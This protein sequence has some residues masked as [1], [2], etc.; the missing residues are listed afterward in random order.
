[1]AAVK[2]EAQYKQYFSGS[3][4]GMD[5]I[6]DDVLTPIF[7]K[8]TPTTSPT[9]VDYADDAHFGNGGANIDHIYDYG[10]F[11]TDKV[12]VS[13]F[14][15]ILADKCQISI[16]RKNIQNT[17][18]R[19]TETYSGAFIVFHYSDGSRNAEAQTWRLS[20]LKRLDV[21]RKDSPAKRY[22]Y[23]CGPSYSCR[24]IAQRFD[25]LQ[26]NSNKTLDSI[27]MA[28]DV[29]ALSKDFFYEYKVFYDDIIQWITGSRYVGEKKTER[30]AGLFKS[31]V[32]L[33][34]LFADKCKDINKKEWAA[35][36]SKQQTDAVEKFVRD[37]V[38]KLMGRMVFLQFIQ[39]KGWLGIS[40]K[41]SDWK[42]GS[43]NFLLE[44]FY[45]CSASN[46][47]FLKDEL[48]AILFDS[49]NKS[50]SK[51]SGGV[52]ITKRDG[53]K[54]PF[55]N[56]G[57][58]E[59]EPAD[60]L[61]IELP[62]DFFH[63][64]ANKD[65]AHVI[66]RK[67]YRENNDDFFSTCG[68]LDF[69]SHYNFTID[70]NASEDDE[71]EVGIDP[72][73]LSKVFENL[74]E[75]NKEKGAFYTPKEIVQ[76]MCKESLVS[77]LCTKIKGIDKEIR[78]F[79][80][81]QLIDK[82]LT[83]Q[84][85]EILNALHKVKICDPAV[86][87][88]AF[89]MGLL[90]LILKLRLVLNDDTVCTDKGYDYAELMS[91]I[92]K[93]E[94][95]INEDD[96]DEKAQLARIKCAIKKHIIQNNI[97]GVDI[98]KGAVDLAR[99][100]FW[101]NI[102]VDEDKPTPLPNL[103]FKIMQGNSL[104]ECYEGID[105]SNLGKMKI[106]KKGKVQ[107]DLFGEID[108]VEK[109]ALYVG[110]AFADF[111]LQ[112]EIKD[113]MDISDPKNK[114]KARK[115]IE[116]YIH[117][118]LITT[119]NVRK[120]EIQQQITRYKCLTD[121]TKK[122]KQD[123]SKKESEEKQIETAIENLQSVINDKFFLWHTWFADVFEN[124]G[125]DI[126]IGNPPYVK[127]YENKDAFNL[128]KKGK[129][130]KA[131]MDLWFYF[132]C[133][134]MDLLKSNGI[135]SFIAQP[136][137]RTSATATILRN[138]I[139]DEATILQLVDFGTYMVFDA[140]TQ[141]MIFVIQNRTASIYDFDFKINDGVL[142]N[143]R[144]LIHFLNEKFS[145]I[146]FDKAKFKN[147]T[148]SFVT[149]NVFNPILSKIKSLENFEL[150][151][152][153]EIIQG[154]IGG[155]DNAFKLTDAETLKF[156]K[157]ESAFIK[158]FYT[159][160]TRYYTPK[161]NEYI[162]YI[163]DK[164]IENV[165][166]DEHPLIYRKLE[167]YKDAL[168][169]RREVLNGRKS[170]FS[171]WWERDEEYF[172]PCPKI[173]YAARTLGRNFTYTEEAFYAS[174]NCFLI[175]TE[176]INLKYLVGFLNSRLL[177]LYM[178]KSLKHN[179]DMLQIDKNQFL[180]IPLF[181]PEHN[182]QKAIIDIVDEILVAKKSNPQVDTT[183]LESKID[184]LVYLLYDLTWDE[185]QIVESSSDHPIYIDKTTY[186]SWRKTYN[187]K[188]IL[189]SEKDMESAIRASFAYTNCT[190]SPRLDLTT[191]EI[192][193]LAQ[194]DHFTDYGFQGI[195]CIDDKHKQI[196]VIL[197]N[198]KIKQVESKI[199]IDEARKRI[200]KIKKLIEKLDEDKKK[201]E[202]KHEKDIEKTKKDFAKKLDALKNKKHSLEEDSVEGNNEETIDQNSLQEKICKLNREYERDLARIKAKRAALEKEKK[203]LE[204]EI[205]K[206]KGEPE[207]TE[208][209][210]IRNVSILGEYYRADSQIILY[211]ETIRKSAFPSYKLFQTYIHEMF[212][213]YYDANPAG[214]DYYIEKV[215]EPITE[216]GALTFI[217]KFTGKNKDKEFMDFAVAQ[218]EKKQFNP[219]VCHYGFGA[220]LFKKDKGLVQQYYDNR[221]KIVNPSS[222]LTA[223][224]DMFKIAYPT[225]ESDCLDKL[226]KVLGII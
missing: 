126:V 23:L 84:K 65:N 153:K 16:A 173:V 131:K 130:Y 95:G 106:L 26:K 80:E 199:T 60:T 225:S 96:C 209:I 205:A 128:I 4:K 61:H 11:Y 91:K 28:F 219:A 79:V 156:S 218:V 21:H 202:I 206:H 54:Y 89:P 33:Y 208:I 179:G 63:N 207:E 142:Q 155:P 73:M 110:D 9:S 147:S 70:E 197:K 111:D 76:Y 220:Y 108:G 41:V 64:E 83:E 215:E 49:L 203:E 217:E 193:T 145:L 102:V 85:G 152:N 161:T 214:P 222:D 55:L 122:Q 27:T 148:F 211:L 196:E 144:D 221:S 10:T 30:K 90:N 20:W 135:L 190:S 31:D 112:K 163:C 105:L 14:E 165:S 48:Y 98:E 29:E 6:I 75:D 114:Q 7:G 88:G 136:Q 133:F 107:C 189:P 97:Y 200:E 187:K 175:K 183:V 140:S 19:I 74:L 150:D 118:I 15:V 159:S 18:R 36:S 72:E 158:P 137:W 167:P 82:K 191:E 182:K 169:K 184:I 138:K 176:K 100:R 188:G 109:D 59:E 123:W 119:L 210:V 68:L 164:N 12:D 194:I 24:T 212:H 170:W 53:L 71:S 67:G 81:T 101:L 181:V 22:T 168:E 35:W 5:S 127:E 223:Y 42:G 166:T 34:K 94:S 13:V 132:A 192:M 1:M 180:D 129:Y 113:Y 50:T 216:L 115:S 154:I 104:L 46:K 198:K 157:T 77:Y 146:Q 57:L 117:Y 38:K 125:F 62:N 44:R 139:C 171:L 151:K 32:D 17:V 116:K 3:F 201:R 2:T 226:K 86:G 124:G 195:N 149:N 56:G 8:F 25:E 162:L 40:D 172:L 204:D 185:M 134:S 174:R 69:F 43:Q 213:A 47:N 121:L 45:K 178:D 37:W 103:D 92:N 177:F 143:K 93:A 78:N 39:K 66:G 99:L 87:S 58:F 141:A 120:L 52:E 160:T 224:E 51:D 186:E